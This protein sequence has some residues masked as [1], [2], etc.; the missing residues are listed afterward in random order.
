MNAIIEIGYCGHPAFPYACIQLE[1]ATKLIPSY[2]QEKYHPYIYGT[3]G[4][5]KTQLVC[6]Y[7]VYRPKKN[8]YRTDIMDNDK[9]AYALAPTYGDGSTDF[10]HHMISVVL[11]SF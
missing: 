6:L 1:K 7:F 10:H 4:N 8:A 3:L 2:F 9:K 11:F 5:K